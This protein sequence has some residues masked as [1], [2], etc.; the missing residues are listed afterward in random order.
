[1]KFKVFFTV[2][3]SIIIAGALFIGFHHFTTANSISE[4]EALKIATQ[5]VHTQEPELDISG[6]K[7]VVMYSEDA[8]TAIPIPIHGAWVV[9]F[10]I[11]S[12]PGYSRPI[13]SHIVMVSRN[14][15]VLLP[16]LTGSP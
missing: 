16:V 5:Y 1:M 3:M 7:P 15:Q 6:R 10:G 11:P 14:G 4:Q 9:N 2:L 8:Y 12:P 13:I